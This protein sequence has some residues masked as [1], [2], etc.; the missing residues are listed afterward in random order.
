MT[1]H[2]KISILLLFLYT[3]STFS[4]Q[5]RDRRAVVIVP[6]A[7]LVGQP[8]GHAT[9]Y[10]KIPLC[11]GK[12]RHLTCKR[13]HQLLFNETVE[14]VQEHGDEVMITIPHAFY[15]TA[16]TNLPQTSYWTLKSNLLPLEKLSHKTLECIPEPLS[17]TNA[18]SPSPSII[19]LSFPLY[20]PTQKVTFSAGTRFIGTY[21]PETD[22]Y[23]VQIIDPHTL[24]CRCMRIARTFCIFP[25]PVHTKRNQLI[26]LIK[27]WIQAYQ[28]C[29]PYVWGGCSFTAPCADNAIREYT[30]KH[31]SY[32]SLKSK[33]STPHTG[34][35]CS[36]II[37]RAAQIVGI[38]YFCKNT[39]TIEKTLPHLHKGQKLEIGDLIVIPGHVMIISDL[40]NNLLIEARSY[41][42]GYGKLHEIPLEKVFKGITSYTQLL[43]AYFGQ[44]PLQRIDKTGKVRD[45]F[46]AFSIIKLPV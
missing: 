13:L 16:S 6:V 29:I 2:I 9:K 15:I 12:N 10:K 32:F 40:T 25:T 14:I 35:D 42:H 19:T 26:T 44:E 34:F 27:S 24:S 20:D 45:T 4:C 39:F 3:F 38:P 11:G 46:E 36:G 43:H 30:T 33:Q 23:L 1:F 41:Q 21:Q 37:V 18:S 31:G 8:L 7:D 22:T 28:G 17:Y 5:P